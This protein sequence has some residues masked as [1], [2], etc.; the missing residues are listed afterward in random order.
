MGYVEYLREWFCIDEVEML[1]S[2]LLKMCG[3]PSMDTWWAEG[4]G[5]INEK[6]DIKRKKIMLIIPIFLLSLNPC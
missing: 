4:A 2:L 3:S 6:E 1:L 5:G